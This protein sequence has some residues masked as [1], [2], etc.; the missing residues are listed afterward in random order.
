MGHTLRKAESR[1]LVIQR[2]M[3]VRP[4]TPALWGKMSAHQMLCHLS[5][6]IR[7]ATGEIRDKDE[8]TFFGRNFIVPMVLLGLPAPKGKVKT[9]R[10]LDFD[11]GAGTAPTDFESDRQTLINYINL[12]ETPREDWHPHPLFGKLSHRKWAR[13]AYTHMDHHLK[14]FGC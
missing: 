14:Q 13:F 10:K 12:F 5:D 4:D 8:S 11:K 2:V 7:L 6:Q 1:K 3:K 9:H